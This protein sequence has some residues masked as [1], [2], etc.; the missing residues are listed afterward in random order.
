MRVKDVRA[1][2]RLMAVD[3]ISARQLAAGAGYASH[4]YVNRI[5]SGQVTTVTPARGRSIARFL[6][7]DVEDLFVAPTSTETRRSAT[8][9]VS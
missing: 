7:V 5:L 8:R 2:K 1:I 9:K 3:N 4:S 6:K